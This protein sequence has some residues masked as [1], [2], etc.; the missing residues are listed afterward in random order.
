MS[1]FVP[2]KIIRHENDDVPYH[3]ADIE[4]LTTAY[5]T[6]LS[7]KAITVS[8]DDTKVTKDLP[9]AYLSVSFNDAKNVSYPAEAK[10]RIIKLPKNMKS[11]KLKSCLKLQPVSVS[12]VNHSTIYQQSFNGRNALAAKLQ[13]QLDKHEFDRLPRS[14]QK[15]FLMDDSNPDKK[16]FIAALRSEI[17]GCNS[18]NTFIATPEGKIIPRHKIGHSKIVFKKKYNADGQF[19]KYKC[20]MVFCGDRW[21]DY[22]NNKTYAGTVMTD[23]VKLILAFFL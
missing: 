8:D 3:I 5:L 6:A 16:G 1:Q 2:D 21:V 4:Q 13:H 23:S 11:I 20:R 9:S 7:N 15:L 10:I 14:V 18:M 12:N 19:E 22:Y 17:E